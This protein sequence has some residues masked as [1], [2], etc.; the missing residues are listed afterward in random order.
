[1]SLAEFG[2][3]IE[4]QS[5]LLWAASGFKNKVVLW[6]GLFGGF[7]LRNT[8]KNLMNNSFPAAMAAAGFYVYA[9]NSI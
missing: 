5:L 6:C 8:F 1:M 2:F 7:E 9:T 4:D 3:K